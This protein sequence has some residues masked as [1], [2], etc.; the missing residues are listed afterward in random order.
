M[1]YYF[2]DDVD[3]YAVLWY[4]QLNIH[5]KIFLKESFKLLCGME[6]E[7]VRKILSLKQVITLYHRK[8]VKEGVISYGGFQY[9]PNEKT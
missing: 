5:K 2:R 9:P 7:E 4:R 6:F 8:L 3:P 1:L